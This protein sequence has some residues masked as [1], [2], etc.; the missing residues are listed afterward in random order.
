MRH[1][2]ISKEYK[3]FNNDDFLLLVYEV[4]AWKFSKGLHNVCETMGR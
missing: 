4:A 3:I 1:V 2:V